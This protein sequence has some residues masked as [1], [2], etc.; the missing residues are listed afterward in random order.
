[1][2]SFLAFTGL[3]AAVPD[4][5]V[6]LVFRLN[7]YGPARIRRAPAKGWLDWVYSL[8]GSAYTVTKTAAETNGFEREAVKLG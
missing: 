6:A 5:A 7:P 2:D 4:G 8:P 1:M 3:F